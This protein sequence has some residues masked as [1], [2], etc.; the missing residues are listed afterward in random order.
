MLCD[1]APIMRLLAG[2]V[3]KWLILTQFSGLVKLQGKKRKDENR[4]ISNCK[5]ETN[6]IWDN[7]LN[8]EMLIQCIQ[9]IGSWGHVR[10][11]T[12]CLP[13]PSGQG[14]RELGSTQP[15]ALEKSLTVLG[16]L[17]KTWGWTRRLVPTGLLTTRNLSFV[18][19][20]SWIQCFKRIH[21]KIKDGSFQLVLNSF[22]NVLLIEDGKLLIKIIN[23]QGSDC[24]SNLEHGFFNSL[25]FI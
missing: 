22:P 14:E 19:F 10:V 17:V 20:A 11:E 15:W 24:N 21:P 2:T 16:S 9:Y 1:K 25:I 13:S 5:V 3:S 12:E 6:I 18:A 8:Q 7:R 23:R 4:S